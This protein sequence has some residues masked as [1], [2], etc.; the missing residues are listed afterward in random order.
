MIARLLLFWFCL[1]LVVPVRAAVLVSEIHYHPVEEA[2]F[3]TNGVP[4]LDLTADVHEF[5]ELHN[6]AAEPVLLTGWS[7]ASSAN[8]PFPEGTVIAA[9]GYLVLAGQPDRITT[10]Y[11]LAEGSVLGPWTGQLGNRKG[12]VRVRD[13]AGKTVDEVSYQ[14][15]SPW[16]ISANAL[17]ADEEWTGLRNADY[18]YR[19]RSL[20]RVSFTQPAS[21]PANWLASPLS[22]PSPGRANTVQR[23]VPKPVVLLRDVRQAADGATL[24]HP[25]N[26]IRIEV[27]FS[28]VNDLQGV[29]VE[30]FLDDIN[31]TNETHNLTPM[32]TG[33]LP[34][35]GRFL[36]D[37]PGQAARSILRW[38][39]RANRGDGDEIVSPR[40]DDPYAWHANFVVPPRPVSTN[41]VYDVFISTAS[42]TTLSTN[43]SQATRRYTLPDPPGLPRKS[44]NATQPIIF[45]RNGVVIDA[46]LRYHGSQFRR[47]P[48]R[49]SYKAKFPAYAP[50]DGRESMFITDKDYR[51]AAGHAVF[52]AAN[53]PTSRT[54]PVDLYLNSNA[55]LLRLAQEEYGGDLLDRYEAEQAVLTGTAA[56]PAGE[57]FKAEGVFDEPSGPYGRG[58]GSLLKLR[59]NRGTNVW[60]PLQRYEWTY[61]LQSHGWKGHTAFKT[62]IDG[63]WAARNNS[64][65]VPTGAQLAKLKTYFDA[66]FDVDRALT[67]MALINWQGAWDD[68]IHNNFLWRQDDGRWSILPWDFDDQFDASVTSVS[69][70]NGAPFAGPNYFKQGLVTAYH[71]RFQQIAWQ[72]NNTLLDPDNL[73][74]L[75]VRL[76]EVPAQLGIGAGPRAGRAAFP[77]VI[78]A[79]RHAEGG[80]QIGR[81][82]V[83]LQGFHAGEPFGPGSTRMPSVFFNMSRCVR[84]RSFSRRKARS[85]ISSASLLHTGTG[86]P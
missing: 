23:E 39:V 76:A 80:A 7:L 83:R 10:V 20:E 68:T 31:R 55:R 52:R 35:E 30:W 12:T 6:T 56:K 82:M 67:H 46:R 25:G 26:P 77:R 70:Y 1:G 40:A 64:V 81:G 49:K 9:N 57:F 72:L 33:G 17:G 74:A 29:Q 15:A 59:T 41:D 14:A 37:L 42:L 78:A 71:D 62:M 84:S 18:Q 13:A 50:F 32:L 65:A 47:D 75:G 48:A 86:G 60:T 27:L 34:A 19:G 79:A 2:A 4:L 85:S 53:L 3:D 45:V 24:L 38:R 16:A 36:A 66:N 5:V 63:M 43:I 54:W 21:D 58:D 51:T 28:A 11:G 44:W 22:G 8:F 73:A 61:A 69:I